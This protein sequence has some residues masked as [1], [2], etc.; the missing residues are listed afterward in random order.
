MGSQHFQ[1]GRRRSTVEY[2][3][4]IGSR[5]LFAQN[6]SCAYVLYYRQI[7]WTEEQQDLLLEEE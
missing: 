7:V 5:D 1:T 2:V 3:S 6:R 4:I